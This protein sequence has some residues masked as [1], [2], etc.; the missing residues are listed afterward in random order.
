MI[1]N[2]SGIKIAY[3]FPNPFKLFVYL[4]FAPTDWKAELKPCNKCNAKKTNAIT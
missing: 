3:P 1:T 4:L 2:P